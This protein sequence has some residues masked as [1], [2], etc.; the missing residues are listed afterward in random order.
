MAWLK[1]GSKRLGVEFAYI[2]LSTLFIYFV[3]TYVILPPNSWEASLFYFIFTY[4]VIA[5]VSLASSDP[6]RIN[7][8]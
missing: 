2:F 4:N 6:G 5:Y 3:Q 8:A 7:D 1:V